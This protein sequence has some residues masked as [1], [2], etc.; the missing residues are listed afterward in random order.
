MSPEQ[1]GA[2][3]AALQRYGAYLTKDLL[4]AKGARASSV[5]VEVRKGRLRMVGTSGN[6]LFSCSAKPEHIGAGVADFVEQFW[7]WKP[8]A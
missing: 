4:I 7:Y 8:L 6:L 3:D 5:G 2:T 1:V